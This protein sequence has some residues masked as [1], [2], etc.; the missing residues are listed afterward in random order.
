MKRLQPHN[1]A[2]R[3]V[4]TVLLATV[5]LAACTTWRTERLPPRQSLANRD[6]KH[7][8][9]TLA[10]GTVTELRYPVLRNDTLWGRSELERQIKVPVSDIRQV[11]T[12][13]LTAGRTAAS[14]LV[15]AAV[16]GGIV[17][18]ATSSGDDE[19]P[20]RSPPSSGGDGY[21]VSC[22]LVYSWDG[23]QWR[24]DSGTFGGAITRGARRTD[25]DNLVFA[26]PQGDRLRL[27]LANE[28]AE[29]DYVD[30]LAVTAVDHAPDRTVAPGADGTIHVLGTLQPPARARDDRGIDVMNRVAAPDGWGWESAL[31]RRDT[32]RAAAIRDGI[33][34]AFVKPAGATTGRLVVDGHNTPWSVLMIRAFIEAHGSGTQAWYDSLDANPELLQRTGRLMARAGFLSV[35]IRANDRYEP[36]GYLVEAGPEVIKRQVIQVDVGAVA[37]DTVYVRLESTPAFWR[38]DH[39]A[40]DFAASDEGWTATELT[41]EEAVDRGGRNVAPLLAAADGRE[42]V[43]EHGDGA[44]LEFSLP[45]V[46]AGRVRSFLL[47]STGWYR[48]HSSARE[49]PDIAMLTR[50][51]REPDAASRLAVARLNDAIRVLEGGAGGAP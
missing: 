16:I 4:A 21:Y 15:V 30:R 23:A 14:V 9:I 34:L 46:P 19:P 1:P 6:L 11:E 38:I 50:L 2:W 32:A 37:G 44:T 27:R 13:G 48:I 18:A 43:M 33:E 7:V 3:A 28:L 42:Y 22:P 26:T 24:L 12:R 39:V 10:D 51:E 17:A 29:T 31:V 41:L 40:M 49:A 25:L 47:R 5:S 45:P 35:A 36:Q 20:R 8:R